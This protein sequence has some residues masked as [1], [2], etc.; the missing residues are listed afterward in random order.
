MGGWLLFF[1]LEFAIRI[2]VQLNVSALSSGWHFSAVSLFFALLGSFSLIVGFAVW[3]MSPAAIWLVR[4][5]LMS[6]FVAGACGLALEM[7]SSKP[8]L[9]GVGLDFTVEPIL[10]FIYFRKSK[11][12]R[13]TFPRID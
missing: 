7:A 4:I 8:F 3:R 6:V 13:A 5:L 11:R 9:H 1:C 10:W 12:V 2:G